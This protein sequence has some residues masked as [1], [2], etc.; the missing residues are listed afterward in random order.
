MYSEIISSFCRNF[1]RFE[2][3]IT[4]IRVTEKYIFHIAYLYNGDILTRSCQVASTSLR[5]VTRAKCG[6]VLTHTFQIWAT[7]S[8]CCI[9][10]LFSLALFFRIPHS[11]LMQR[12]CKFT[13]GINMISRSLP[14][15]TIIPSIRIFHKSNINLKNVN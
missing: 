14:L 12:Q 4:K 8:D 5:D 6:K 11:Q 9:I 1:V 2:A 10:L 13:I 15:T 7:W 3:K